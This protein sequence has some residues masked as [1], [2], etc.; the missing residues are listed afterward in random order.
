MRIANFARSIAV[1]LVEQTPQSRHKQNGIGH[2]MI[3]RGTPHCRDL[4][5]RRAQVAAGGRYQPQS[6]QLQAA[7]LPRQPA[8]LKSSRAM[9]FMD[10]GTRAVTN[11]EHALILTML[12]TAIE[13]A[14]CRAATT[15]LR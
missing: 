1:E 7:P 5:I 10:N 15:K 3:P 4:A 13:A 6:L 14:S 2:R 12:L 9:G 11:T 8:G